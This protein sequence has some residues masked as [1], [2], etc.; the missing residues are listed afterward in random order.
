MG[1]GLLGL[2]IVV[3]FLPVFGKGERL[4]PALAQTWLLPG[5]LQ[6]SG[7]YKGAKGAHGNIRIN[8]SKQISFGFATAPLGAISWSL[9]QL[10]S[11]GYP[12]Q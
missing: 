4:S 2:F 12:D 6:N 10:L 5:R 3:I 11:L 9:F 7:E 1:S 8:S